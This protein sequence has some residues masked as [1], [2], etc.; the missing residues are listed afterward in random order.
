MIRGFRTLR[1]IYGRK[2][3]R[4]MNRKLFLSKVQGIIHIGAHA[5]GEANTYYIH[6]LRVAWVEPIPGVFEQLCQNIALFKKQKAYRYLIGEQD[7]PEAILHLSTNDGLSSSVLP[8]AKHRDVWPHISYCGEIRMPMTSLP[9]FVQ[10]ERLDLANYQALILDTQGS[11]LMILRGAGEI[12]RAFRFIQV[13]VADFEAYTGCCL[14]SEMNNFM[15][16]NGFHQDRCERHEF[17][18]SAEVGSYYD[19]TYVRIGNAK[20]LHKP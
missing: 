11:E 15:S 10:Q 1:A 6:D 2:R 9:T 4:W 16:D 12:L 13:E 14:L 17:P 7:E 18:V 19:I 20:A 8:L 5:G 3:I